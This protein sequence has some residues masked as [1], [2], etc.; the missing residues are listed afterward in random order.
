MVFTRNDEARSS[1][2]PGA[3]LQELVSMQERCSQ[4]QHAL[5]N[6]E[7]ARDE[8]VERL[9]DVQHAQDM[10]EARVEMCTDVLREKDAELREKDR[11]LQRLKYVLG[12]ALGDGQGRK[13]DTMHELWDL[14]TSDPPR[15]SKKRKFTETAD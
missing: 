8:S 1:P 12:L 4:L 5:D 15:C 10:A 11:K 14:A 9:H 13:D 3:L 6:A 2:L 7:R